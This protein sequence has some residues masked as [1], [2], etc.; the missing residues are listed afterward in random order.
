MIIE[1]IAFFHSPFPS[2]FG[3]PRQSGIVDKLRGSIEFTPAYRRPDALR[4]LERFDYLW[5][6]WGFSEHV[7]APKHDT[8]RPPLLGGNE[9]VGVWA[10]RSPFRPNNLGLSSVRILSVDA[11]A[12]TI[13]VAGADLMD[14]TPIYD[15]KPYLPYAD[16]HADARAGFTESRKWQ[17]LSV[18]TD[19]AMPQSLS[20]DDWAALQA[21][22]AQDPR[23]QY[24]EDAD[25]EY[26]M[27]Y[28]DWEV[29]FKVVGSVLHVVGWYP[30]S[31]ESSETLK[32][33][34]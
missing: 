30:A 18:V 15:V 27:S 1:P 2:K 3:I 32:C 11:C 8:V 6:I 31:Q 24:H 23:P 28:M 19:A 10:T 16:S 9:R 29:A 14:G 26:R 4:G 22:L 33:M 12:M 7:S 25:R 13:H 5:L 21:V 17:Q 20:A 34:K